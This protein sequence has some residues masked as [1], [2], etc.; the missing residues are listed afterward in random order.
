MRFALGGAD[1]NL[2]YARSVMRT[3]D[4]LAGNPG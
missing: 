1:P 3:C 4:T 2:P